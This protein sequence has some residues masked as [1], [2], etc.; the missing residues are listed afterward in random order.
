MSEPELT[1]DWREY[2]SAIAA[3]FQDPGFSAN[4]NERVSGVRAGHDIDVLVL[5]RQFGVVTRWIVEAKHWQTRV[6][7]E[8]V[9]ALLSIVQDVGADRGFLVAEKGFQPGRA[10]PRG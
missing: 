3:F 7:K 10:T 1:P 5:S 4:E 9:E 6:T 8:K 2:Q